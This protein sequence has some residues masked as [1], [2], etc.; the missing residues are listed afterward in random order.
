M[1]ATT[2]SES[3]A[4]IYPG[5]VTTAI[6]AVEAKLADL[7]ADTIARLEASATM[8][9]DEFLTFGPLPAEMHA[10]GLLDLNS[11]QVLHFIH[12]DFDGA[13]L[14]ARI[15]FLQVM[16]EFLAAKLGVRA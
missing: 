2:T 6:V 15:V 1:S 9:D 5:K 13:S 7:D 14:A 10:S 3:L 16:G 8:G 12:N 4:H 11:N